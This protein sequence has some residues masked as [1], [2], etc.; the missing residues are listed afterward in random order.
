MFVKGTPYI[1]Q[2]MSAK[3]RNEYSQ[4]VKGKS[5]RPNHP[6]HQQPPMIPP[7]MM[8]GMPMYMNMNMAMGPYGGINIPQQPYPP[9]NMH[10]KFQQQG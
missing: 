6:P 8:G 4:F 1:T 7:P 10:N 3:D 5:D 2:H 9:M